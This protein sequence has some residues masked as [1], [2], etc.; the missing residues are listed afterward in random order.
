MQSPFNSGILMFG[1]AIPAWNMR[2]IVT[3]F[4]SY[5]GMYMA[6]SFCHSLIT[7]VIAGSALRAWDIQDPVARQRFRILVILV[8]IFSFPL[9]QLFNP[10]RSLSP[11]RFQALFDVN[12]WLMLEVW[13]IFPLG[14][15]LLAVLI[16]TAIVFLVQEMIPILKHSAQSRSSRP[17]GKRRVPNAF[18][19]SFAK[20]LS[21][22]APEI[23]ILDDDEPVLFS[24]TGKLPAICISSGL[25]A[26]LTPGQVRAAF[27]HEVAHIARSRRPLLIAV[28]LLR[29]IMFYNPVALMKFRHAVR[30]EEK[31]CD[32]IAASLTGDPGALAGALE[33]FLH[34]QPDLPDLQHQNLQAFTSSLEEKN[35]NLHLESRIKRLRQPQPR[36]DRGTGALISALAAAVVL[37]Y[38]IV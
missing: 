2:Y 38:F 16:T 24:I 23:V 20:A 1:N 8:P 35:H 12:R 6:Q 15:M 14:L 26:L 28:F 4:N 32:D 37:N 29:I 19:Q 3:F 33:K 13:G 34:K 10:A 22:E 27:A 17:E 9:Y 25:M 36:P 5:A 31:I 21:I 7:A 18:V 30:D 11:F